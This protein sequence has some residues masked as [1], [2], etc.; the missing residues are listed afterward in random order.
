MNLHLGPESCAPP[1]TSTSKPHSIFAIGDLSPYPVSFTSHSSR[2]QQP[3]ARIAAPSSSASASGYSPLGAPRSA[4]V[5]VRR[6]HSPRSTDLTVVA[7]LLIIV[8]LALVIA[9]FFL[10]VAAATAIPSLR[11]FVS[12]KEKANSESGTCSS[13]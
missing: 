2:R 8:V 10:G 3:Q 9:S 6:G 1:S 12:G 7:I 5:I 11:G 13:S 4:S